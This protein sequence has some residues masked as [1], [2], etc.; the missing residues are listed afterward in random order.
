M[1][2]TPTSTVALLMLARLVAP[3]N[4]PGRCAVWLH[5]GAMIGTLLSNRRCRRTSSPKLEPQSW[6]GFSSGAPGTFSMTYGLP[7]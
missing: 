2:H 6:T 4:R 5:G 7:G 3:G 1:R